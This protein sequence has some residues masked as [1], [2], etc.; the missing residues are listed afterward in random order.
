MREVRYHFQVVLVV[1]FKDNGEKTTDD[2]RKGCFVNV[3]IFFA[4]PL[5]VLYKIFFLLRNKIVH[6]K[7][8]VFVIITLTFSS[9]TFSNPTMFLVYIQ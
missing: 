7:F 8:Y 6:L 3:G 2:C 4:S 9:L 1:Y 5:I